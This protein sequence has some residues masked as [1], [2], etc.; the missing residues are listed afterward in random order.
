MI[1]TFEIQKTDDGSITFISSEF[2]ESF[3]TKYGAKNEAEIT[4]VQ[5]CQLLEKAKNQPSFKILDICYGLGYNTAQALSCIWSINP[6]CQ[7]QIMALELDE[8]VPLQAIDNQ[9]LNSWQPLIID[10]LTKLATKKTISR[11]NLQAEL[12]I[13]D[14]RISIQKLAALNF[15]AD[16][17]FLDPFSPPKCPQLWTVEFLNLVAKCLNKTGII[18]TYSC[19]ASIRY[20]LQLAQLNIGQNKSIGRRS[21]GTLAS[22][23]SKYIVP[24]S[25][26]EIE[27][28]KTR[29]AIPY[30]D[31]NLHDSTEII[32]ERREKEQAESQ[33]EP[34]TKWKKR[35][36]F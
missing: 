35:W 1:N 31:P 13:E 7:I 30:R 21:P 26:I 8:R 36:F 10:L 33:L 5:G 32:K 22:F 14:A 20:A 15:Q 23:S 4:Y 17:I 29:A 12:L 18:A 16:A 34:T 27:H 9:L 6:N 19:S 3:H 24:L 28:L 11:Q 2:G 25:L